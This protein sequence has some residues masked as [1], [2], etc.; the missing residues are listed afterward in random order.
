MYVN[1][2]VVYH[3]ISSPS[4]SL[5]FTLFKKN[6]FVVNIGDQQC[7]LGKFLRFYD[8]RTKEKKKKKKEKINMASHIP[9]D[10]HIKKKICN[11]CITA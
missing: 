7:V 6:V 9:A 3:P 8:K 10:T 1:P 2:T 4:L 5:S 11:L